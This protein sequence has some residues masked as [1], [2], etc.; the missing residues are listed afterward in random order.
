MASSS[1]V[2]LIL[3]P[4][5][6]LFTL[7]NVTNV[8]SI[9]QGK[10]E[11]RETKYWLRLLSESG[12][13]DDYTKKAEVFSA[14]D[15]I[16]NIITKIVKTS[17]NP[18]P[19]TQN[20]KL[21]TQHRLSSLPSLTQNP[22]LKTQHRFSHEPNEL[23]RLYEPLAPRTSLL[24]LRTSFLITLHSLLITHHIT[25]H[26]PRAC[27]NWKH[28]V[29]F[30]QAGMMLMILRRESGNSRYGPECLRGGGESDA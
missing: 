17:S 15:S 22:T 7:L 10:K 2:K 5:C 27:K 13:L 16:I 6:P 28:K 20:S 25:H 11:A 30:Q 21:N 29:Y 8:L 4:K 18:K 14:A 12:H 24:A 1:K 26:S 9:E 3:S 19:N 23:N